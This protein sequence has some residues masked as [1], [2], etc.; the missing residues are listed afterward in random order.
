MRK[1]L[2]VLLVVLLVF[3][4]MFMGGASVLATPSSTIS[5]KILMPAGMLAP[6]GGFSGS[7]FAVEPSGVSYSASFT[8]V[9]ATSSADYSIN[10]PSGN[11]TPSY[12]VSVNIST[13]TTAIMKM[14]YYSSTGTTLAYNKKSLINTRSGSLADIDI[15]LLKASTI[16]GRIS[17]P[18]A[19]LAPAGGIGFS[20]R[21]SDSSGYYSFYTSPMIAAG[22][23]FIDYVIVVPFGNATPDYKIVFSITSNS[24]GYINKGY[25]S[26]GG[27]TTDAAA[28]T[29]VNTRVGNLVGYN[30]TVLQG[31]NITGKIFLPVGVT[32]PVGGISLTIYVADTTISSNYYY[33]SIRILEGANF[34]N[35]SMTVPFGV[36]TPDYSV[37]YYTSYVTGGYLEKGYYSSLGTKPVSS[38]ATPVNTR[39]GSISGIDLLFTKGNSISGKLTLPE[40][41]VAPVGG[42]AFNIYADDESK[43]YTFYSDAYILEGDSSVNYSISVPSGSSIPKFSVSYYSSG[44]YG[45]FIYN[46]YYSTKGTSGSINDATY[47]NAGSGSKTNVNLKVLIM[48]F[49][50]INISNT[51]ATVKITKTLLLTAQGYPT[52]D[53]KA[54]FKWKSSNTAVATVTSA[55]LVMAKSVGT[56]TIT[57]TSS[58]GGKKAICK[59]KVIRPVTSVKLSKSSITILKNK[60]FKLSAIVSPTNATIKSVKW[61]S[62][63]PLIVSI[64]SNGTVKGIK[65]GT[66]FVMATTVEG[67]KTAKCKVTVK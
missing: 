5:G 7:I 57:A 38:L 6:A 13:N 24:T 58:F 12:Y 39:G 41:L 30:M 40:G 15:T 63:D 2:S 20:L 16:S 8:I 60:T 49:N 44:Y 43:L 19:Q 35:Y 64:S 31:N 42:L 46:A 11:N 10:V 66:V 3:S 22:T 27:T 67:G 34:V 36:T 52:I 4:A 65:K 25:Y 21:A 45:G 28:A 33:N 56:A 59:I 53:A 48:P 23:N 29:S 62:L 50:K 17:L 61:K 1:L 47:I 51:K 32:A 55:G 26:S 14:G 9:A 18:G 37:Y 54:T